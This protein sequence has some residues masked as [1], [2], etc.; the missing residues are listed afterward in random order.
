MTVVTTAVVVV[1]SPANV[2]REEVTGEV[3]EGNEVEEETVMTLVLLVLGTTKDTDFGD[4]VAP[5]TSQLVS[6]IVQCMPAGDSRHCFEALYQ[7]FKGAD[8]GDEATSTPPLLVW[9]IFQ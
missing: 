1:I 3:E 6:W 7:P 4:E 5:I 2:P 8:L 9:W